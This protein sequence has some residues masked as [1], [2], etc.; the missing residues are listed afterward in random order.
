MWKHIK[1]YLG[2]NKKERSGVM[3]LLAILLSVIAANTIIP[4]FNKQKENYSNEK[5]L[6]IVENFKKERNKK[7]ILKEEKPNYYNPKKTKEIEYFNFNPN[8]LSKEKWEQLGLH[9]AQITIIKNYEAKGGKFYKS[10]DLKKIYGISEQ[11]YAQL[12]PFI[13]IPNTKKHK[14]TYHKTKKRPFKNT[15]T[16]TIIDINSAD[17]TELMKISGIGT[18]FSSRIIKFR[19]YLGGFYTKK[20]LYE[21]YGLDSADYHRIAPQI[22]IETQHIRKINL[23]TA[24]FKELLRHPYLDYYTVKQIVQYRE[25]HGRFTETNSLKNVDLIYDD[26]YKKIIPYLTLK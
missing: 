23:N 13:S 4:L 9:S 14:T 1:N 11:Q 20:Q 16:V 26:L 17:S 3:T 18:V 15:K 22:K 2:F 25:D 19:K 12:E 6:E 8:N 10:S 21:V 5:F 24:T 7:N